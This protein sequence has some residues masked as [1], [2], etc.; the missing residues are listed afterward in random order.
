MVAWGV[1]KFLHKDLSWGNLD[2]FGQKELVHVGSLVSH[3]SNFYG[4][5][6]GSRSHERKHRRRRSIWREELL[7]SLWFSLKNRQE[8]VWRLLRQRKEIGARKGM[9]LAVCAL[10]VKGQS[11]LLRTRTLR[12]NNAVEPV[13]HQNR[14]KRDSRANCQRWE[15]LS[16]LITFKF[17]AKITHTPWILTPG[18]FYPDRSGGHMV[19]R[20]KS[21]DVM[22]S[23]SSGESHPTLWLVSFLFP[24]WCLDIAKIDKTPL[25]YSFHISIWGDLYFQF[26]GT[27][28]TSTGGIF[29]FFFTFSFI[30]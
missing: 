3:A 12:P 21:P 7:L 1:T 13:H 22:V 8:N 29:G 26:G 17:S 4:S 9:H 30:C 25:I 14:T 2:Q 18:D 5:Q 6:Q 27:L 20:W 24:S 11:I 23:V 10:V 16:A 15:H 19:P 28:M